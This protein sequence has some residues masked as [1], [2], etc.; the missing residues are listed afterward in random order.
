MNWDDYPNFSEQELACSHCGACSMH[1]DIMRILQSMRD[2][3]KRPIYISSGYRCKDHPV[4]TMKDKPGEHAHG[5]AVD[6]IC[7]G[8]VALEFLRYA[9]N[10]GITRI[11][12][13]QKGR[14]SGRFIH[15]GI[16]DHHTSEFPS[17]AIWT[18]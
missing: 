11:G 4:E 2:M 12:L 10:M 16:A 9:S 3:H 15:I 13:N 18:Y 1:P 5:M 14:A 17:N 8:N 6:I 7:N